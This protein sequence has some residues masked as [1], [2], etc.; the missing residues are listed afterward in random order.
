MYNHEDSKYLSILPREVLN[1]KTSKILML[2]NRKSCWI[3]EKKF[4]C[5]L[6][7]SL[8][9][10][11]KHQHIVLFLCIGSWI[12]AKCLQIWTQGEGSY[13]DDSW[14]RRW[15]N[16]LHGSS[17]R[18]WTEGQP[19]KFI[20]A[21]RLMGEVMSAHHFFLSYCNFFILSSG[22]STFVN[23]IPPVCCVLKKKVRG[24][25]HRLFALGLARNWASVTS[26]HASVKRDAETA[27]R[28]HF[29]VHPI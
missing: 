9:R 19:Q 1:G 6:S 28:V 3:M 7:A 15:M 4:Q 23:M 25:Y 24:A 11:L 8:L 14:E 22:I 10:L 20:G 26:E 16:L 2:K 17:Q 18:G 29:E 12:L 21:V 13:K 27:P 5:E